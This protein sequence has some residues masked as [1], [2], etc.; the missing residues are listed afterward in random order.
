MRHTM[1]MN[2]AFL[3]GHAESLGP[4]QIGECIKSRHGWN[5]NYVQYML[6]G[7]AYA[8]RHTVSLGSLP[9]D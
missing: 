1:R 4:Q 3:D 9:T 6:P 7:E 5:D 8:D 2:S